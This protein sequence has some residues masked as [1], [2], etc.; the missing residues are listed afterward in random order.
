MSCQAVSGRVA[1]TGEA[2]AFMRRQT[3]R[4]MARLN[5]LGPSA[6][7]HVNRPGESGASTKPGAVQGVTP[8]RSVVAEQGP[9]ARPMG[10]V[11]REGEDQ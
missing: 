11:P 4:A 1:V 9:P 2:W 3:S 8:T 7:G 5:S 6:R 10:R